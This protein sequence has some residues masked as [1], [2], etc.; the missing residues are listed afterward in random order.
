MDVHIGLPIIQWG[1]LRG[2]VLSSDCQ[3]QQIIVLLI[4]GMCKGV[5]LNN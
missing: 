5:D 4:V 3:V 1:F 2:Y